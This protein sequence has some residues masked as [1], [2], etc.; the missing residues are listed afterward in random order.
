[1]SSEKKKRKIK[2]GKSKKNGNSADN[3]DFKSGLEV[4]NGS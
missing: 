3:G 1:M 4:I 2:L